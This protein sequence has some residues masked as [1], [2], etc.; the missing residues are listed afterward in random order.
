MFKNIFVVLAS[1]VLLFFYIR[2]M[3][4]K[5]LYIPFRQID[6]TPEGLGLEYVDLSITTPDR[7]VINAWFIPKEEPRAT[8]LFLHGNGGN[9]SHRLTKIAFFYELGVNVFIFDYRGYGK[10]KGI[11]SEKGL[12]TDAQ[13]CYDYVTKILKIS[14]DKIILYG[15]SLGGAV[16]ID[17]ASRNRVKAL[18]LEGVFPSVV[19]MA[20]RLL[21]FLP[22]FLLSS[23]FDSV[24]KIDKISVPKLFIHSCNDE[25]IPFDLGKKVFDRAVSPKEF[26]EIHG[27]HNDAFFNQI[28]IL[29]KRIWDFLEQIKS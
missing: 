23:K 9:L 10:S 16:A 7:I 2:Y 27:G 12:Y 19:D 13:A 20:R 26:F 29:K 4:R 11:P 28:G 5:S 17:L 6:E 22:S 8:I 24:S 25:I 1:L 18:I 14:P 15:E 3:E 21:P